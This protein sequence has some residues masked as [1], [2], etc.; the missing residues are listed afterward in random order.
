MEL[1]TQKIVSKFSKIWFWDPGKT[2]SGSR[3]LKGTGAWIRIRNTAAILL[4]C[5]VQGLGWRSE[6]GE[7]RDG[8]GEG[9]RLRGHRR[10]KGPHRR[11]R[12]RRSLQVFIFFIF[13]SFFFYVLISRLLNLPPL[14]FHCVG[15][16]NPGL[17]RL[18]HWQSD[19]LTPRLDLIYII[20]F[21]EFFK[22]F[23][24]SEIWSYG[25]VVRVFITRPETSVA[26]PG[27]GI[28]CFL[29]PGSGIGFF[30][31]PN[32]FLRHFKAK[33]IYNFVKFVGT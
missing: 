24:S 8:A 31:I 30:R 26:D 23:T 19:T 22:V 28:G 7:D 33:I 15:G 6:G 12:P 21:D 32:F 25:A 1:F 27:S 13:F 18:R 4:C 2:Y 9:S 29:T 16:S 11:H 14:R 5:C 3:G 10:Q 17:V 20:F